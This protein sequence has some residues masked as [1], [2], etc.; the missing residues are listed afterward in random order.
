[1]RQTL[2][3]LAMA[4]CSGAA[5]AQPVTETV[6]ASTA[7]PAVD[8]S[9][10][11]EDVKFKTGGDE[12]MTVPVRLS[13]S[14]PYRFLV[15]TGADRTAISRQL[16]GRLGLSRSDDATI[17]TV[18]GAST[19]STTNLPQLQMTRDPVSVRHAPLLESANM[20]ADGILGI[21]SLK[22]QRVQFDFE[23]QTLSVV[24]SAKPDFRDEPGT[25]VVQA[26]R[27]KGRLILADARAN[28]EPVTVVIDTGA[29]LSIGN[30]A[31]RQ[32]LLQR[33]EAQSIQKVSLLSVTGQTIVGDYAFIRELEIGGV[34]LRNLAIVF[35]DAHSFKTLKLDR[36]PALLLGMNA[37]RA[38]KK[39]SIDFARQKFRVVLP[40]KSELDVRIAL[41]RLR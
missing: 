21:D 23:K 8:N 34:T 38:F 5:T 9:T 27:R 22:A 7:A 3:A 13:G 20:G 36:R 24:P 37:I 28:D 6:T 17:H 26:E 32:R 35:T 29:Q 16:A 33:G 31:L 15:D 11:T 1:M 18:T 41:A 2:I 4:A 30:E 39:V 19:V 40:E 10:Q 25:I 14:G 12:R